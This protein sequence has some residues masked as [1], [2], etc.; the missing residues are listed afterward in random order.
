[1]ASVTRTLNPVEEEYLRTF[2]LTPQGTRTPPQPSGPIAP[3]PRPDLCTTLAASPVGTIPPD[4]AGTASPYGTSSSAPRTT[5][6]ASPGRIPSWLGG[7]NAP[8]WVHPY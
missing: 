4:A 7:P 8:I 5:G 6:C 2:R 1:M 3:Q